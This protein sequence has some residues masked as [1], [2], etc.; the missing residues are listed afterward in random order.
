VAAGHLVSLW[1]WAGLNK[2][3]STGYM[4]EAA[5]F[6]FNA[7]PVRPPFLER[8]FGVMIIAAEVSIGVLLLTARWRRIGIVLAIGLH[9]LGLVALVNIRWNE[10][11]WPWNV[12]LPLA[13]VAFFWARPEG[14]S[15][16][17]RT[18]I[19]AAFLVVPAGFYA[20]V[21]DAYLAHNLYTS[22]TAGAVICK[23]DTSCV[24]GPWSETFTTLNVP[25]PPEPRLYRDYF[26]E[27]C[28][29]G[30][31]LV[32]S[33]RRTR[34]LFGVNSASSTYACTTASG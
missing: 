9:V 3:L 32:V 25:L 29:P 10:S 1:L 2:A 6:L 15:P 27:V 34:I 26:E 11:V 33:P 18:A 28:A 31:T 12:A 13:A 14:P 24:P 17:R 22:N 7:F 20:G 4:G 19:M 30:D 8:P 5:R 23:P 21:V 16:R